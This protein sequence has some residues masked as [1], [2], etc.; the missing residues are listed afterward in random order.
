[1]SAA[2][3][4]SLPWSAAIVV[5]S[6]LAM[7]LHEMERDLRRGR[8]PRRDRDAHRIAMREVAGVIGALDAWGVPSPASVVASGLGQADGEGVH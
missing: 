5:R 2:G 6:A 3:S 8:V 1:V 4:F 7:M